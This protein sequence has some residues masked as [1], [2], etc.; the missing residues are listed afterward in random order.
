VSR[1]KSFHFSLGDSTFGPI[2]FSARVTAKSSKQAVEK[3]KKAIEWFNAELD[4]AKATGLKGES[5]GV[6][7]LEVYF[8]PDLISEKDIIEVNPVEEVA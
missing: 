6:E 2:G 1:N 3:L 8:K 7:Y 5:P 4:V